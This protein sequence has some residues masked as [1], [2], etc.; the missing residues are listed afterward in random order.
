MNH[1]QFMV[2]RD[3]TKVYPMG[4]TEVHALG[5]ADKAAIQRVEVPSCQLPDSGT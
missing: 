2:L 3:V 4:D 1:E 5:A